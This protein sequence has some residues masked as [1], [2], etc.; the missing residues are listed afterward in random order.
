[1]RVVV[2]DDYQRVALT[3]ADW[4][5]VTDIAVVDVHSDHDP[6]PER[7]VARLAPYDVVVLMRERTPLP[8]AVIEALPTLRLIVTTGRANAAIDLDAA[9]RQGITVCGTE[10]LASAPAELT[11]ALVLGLARHLPTEIDNLRSGRWQSTVGVGM[12]GR[13]LGVVGLGRIG[14]RVARVGVALGM[15]VVAW[16]RHLTDER[17]RTVGASAVDLDALLSGSDVVTLHLPLTPVTRGL[18]DADR[19]ALMKP[20]ALLVNTARAGLL[21]LD[22][23]VRAVS[24]G[25]LAGLGLDVFEQEPLAADD[26]LRSTPGVLTT[27]HLGFVADDVYA[28]FFRQVVE[29]II[30]FTAGSPVRVIG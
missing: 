4:G 13:S 5:P 16:S 10:S 28:L 12:D 15:E 22:A 14:S 30:A 27:P 23:A 9:R 24:E 17:A 29:D 18:I 7:L 2:L 20:T 3:S 26:P 6:D 25:R 1:M 21:D 11:W 19:I 8:R